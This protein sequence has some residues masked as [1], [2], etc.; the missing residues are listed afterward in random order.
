MNDSEPGVTII[1]KVLQELLKGH[2]YFQNA[3]SILKR[4]LERDLKP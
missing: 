4:Y 2:N 1:Y 3:L